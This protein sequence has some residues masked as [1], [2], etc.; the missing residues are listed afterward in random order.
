MGFSMG[1][2]DLSKIR[3]DKK[4]FAA[5]PRAKSRYVLLISG[6]IAV[7]AGWVLYRTGL[8]RPAVDVQVATVQTIYPSQ[9]F[10]LLNASGYVVA[11]RKAAVAS[12]ITG[13]LVYLAVEEGDHV[14]AGQIIARLE[15]RDLQAAR[16]RASENVKVARYNLVQ[17][18]AELQE[19]LLAYTRHKE[20]WAKRLIAQSTFDTVEARY[21]KAKAGVDSQA[22]A[23]KASQAAL[24]EAEINYDYANIRAP[25][26]GVVLSKS[27]DVGDIVTPLAAT[28]EAKAAVVTI[29]DMNSLQVEVDV[30]ESN[31]AQV[32]EGQPC[33]VQLDA[34]PDTRF[35]G[36]VHRIVPTAD[37]TKAS[38]MVKVAFVD[39][40]S[41]ILPE[42]SAK[43][44]FLERDV[45]PEDRAAVTV[46][47]AA[48][49]VARSG[50]HAVF[51]IRGQRAVEEPV[52]LGRRMGD[53]V[54][55]L[56][57]PP[58]G[59]KVVLAPVERITD[60]VRVK[61]PLS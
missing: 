49:V 1:P 52:R 19:A 27:A 30:S 33:E 39:K 37:R 9:M 50:D 48:A 60:G 57:G 13:R 23:V 15:N 6:L 29:A 8:L 24:E 26:D 3:I 51:V 44:A 54:Q 18:Q 45:T 36:R 28:T 53:M 46:I 32:R 55:L 41:R 2:D 56:D 4:A 11:D 47:P 17:A 38:V 43:V 22:A 14:K 12:K 59:D 34:L 40:D 42:M 25:F 61:V 21:K 16:D 10:T 31:I 58:I 20:L 7:A 5:R 35:R